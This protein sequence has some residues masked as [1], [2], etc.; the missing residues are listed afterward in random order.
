MGG[1]KID[2]GE[3]F[4]DALERNE[5]QGENLYVLLPTSEQ[6]IDKVSL[7]CVHVLLCLCV[8]SVVVCFDACVCAR[9]HDCVYCVLSASLLPPDWFASFLS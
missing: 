4:I 3:T 5:E 8:C 6:L 7:V 9:G 2:G 1:V